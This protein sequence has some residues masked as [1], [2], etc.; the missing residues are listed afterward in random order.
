MILWRNRR[1]YARNGI[2]NS[3]VSSFI[4]CQQI[5]VKLLSKGSHCPTKDNLPQPAVTSLALA[6]EFCAVALDVA[7]TQA[8]HEDTRMMPHY[9]IFCSCF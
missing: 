2:K 9:G 3:K 4:C 7:K 8:N 6:A 1:S 5:C